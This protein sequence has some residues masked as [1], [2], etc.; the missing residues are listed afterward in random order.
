MK[1]RYIR[2]YERL[3]AELSK[4]QKAQAEL[5]QPL[6]R[7]PPAAKCSEQ[8]TGHGRLPDAQ[9]E[10]Q[11]MDTRARYTK[12]RIRKLLRNSL[13]WSSSPNV[14]SL[15]TD[16][17]QALF[18]SRVVHPYLKGGITGRSASSSRDVDYIQTCYIWNKYVLE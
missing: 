7:C 16:I 13:S 11:I 6:W 4:P 2:D 12:E 9:S 8:S 3:Q 14:I 18:H 1:D 15:L 10:V 17:P 5:S